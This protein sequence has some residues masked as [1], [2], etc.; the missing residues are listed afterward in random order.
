MLGSRPA[1]VAV[2]GWR[3]RRVIRPIMAHLAMASV[4]LGSRL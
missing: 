4:C 2:Q 3:S 1:M